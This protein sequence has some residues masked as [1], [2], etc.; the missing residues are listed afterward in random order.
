MKPAAATVT[1]LYNWHRSVR[2]DSVTSTHTVGY[3]THLGEFSHP[4][5][6]RSFSL[7]EPIPS[8]TPVPIFVN[9]LDKYPGD[10]HL[11]PHEWAF[12]CSRLPL[13]AE[14]SR[15]IVDADKLSAVS[16]PTEFVAQVDASL[17]A[18]VERQKP[19][20]NRIGTN[21]W[22]HPLNSNEISAY[23][24]AYVRS[25]HCGP[26]SKSQLLISRLCHFCVYTLLSL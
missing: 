6:E 14:E 24:D 23:G 20:M 12:L 25:M 26:H 15:D 7:S 18:T 8:G 10:H 16:I 1:G 11:R 3:V 13:P 4:R 2:S 17:H 9:T 21:K 19:F 5:K 22:F